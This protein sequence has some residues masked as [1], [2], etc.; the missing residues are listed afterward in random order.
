MFER[1]SAWIYKSVTDS[2]IFVNKS[3]RPVLETSSNYQLKR[4]DYPK[5]ICSWLW[6]YYRKVGLINNS[7]KA[8]LDRQLSAQ[9]S[10]SVLGLFLIS[11]HYFLSV[12]LS[13]NGILATNS[14]DN[15]HVK[16]EYDKVTHI[17]Y[18]IQLKFDCLYVLPKSLQQTTYSLLLL[19]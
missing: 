1:C 14:S 16:L 12:F 15:L 18:L 3:F 7:W 2:V 6:H 13:A 8:I 11:P 10:F 5:V 4:F 19:H 9:I 17:T